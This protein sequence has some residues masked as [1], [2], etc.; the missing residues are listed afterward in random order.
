[1]KKFL[2][3]ARHYKALVVVATTLILS[4]CA[5]GPDRSSSDQ[6]T[7]RL[8][9][10]PSDARIL[11]ESA[12]DVFSER[13]IESALAVDEAMVVASEWE[14]VN[15]EL[16][17]RLIVRVIEVHGGRGVALNITSEYLRR[18][19]DSGEEYWIPAE[20]ELTKKRARTDELEL[21][22]SIKERYEERK[23]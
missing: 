15:K 23:E 1:M 9:D 17:H 13:G 8:I 14:Q 22:K 6:K 20:D 18:T 10:E 4:A 11:F 16:R 5:S 19:L 21:G 2:N 7:E 12:K 3:F